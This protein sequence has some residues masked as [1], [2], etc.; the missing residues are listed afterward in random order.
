VLASSNFNHKQ[1]I[2]NNKQALTPLTRYQ[3]LSRALAC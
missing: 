2:W 3:L 1:R